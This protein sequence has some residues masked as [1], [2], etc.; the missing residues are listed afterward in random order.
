MQFMT[1]RSMLKRGLTITAAAAASAGVPH[2]L[3]AE[4]LVTVPGIQL[5]TVDKELKADVEGTLKKVRAIGYREV[6]TAGFGGR[7]EE[8]FQNAL[9]PL[10]R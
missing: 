6:E 1:R 10:S 3:W 8:A 2:S 9:D 4:P 7:S 5:Y